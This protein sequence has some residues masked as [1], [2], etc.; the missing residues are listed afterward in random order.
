MNVRSDRTS[1][2]TVITVVS[3][4]PRSGTSLLMQMLRAGGMPLLTDDER[5][6]D[7]DNPRGYFEFDPVK[8]VR[9]DRTWLNQA[10]G[11]A[12]KI[13]HFLL[14]ELPVDPPFA[15][16]VLFMRRP[17]EEVLA[18]QQ[19]MLSRQGKPSANEDVLK[20][21]YQSQVRSAETWMADHACVRSLNVDYHEAL[22]HP[23][24]IAKDICA[25]LEADLDAAAM[26]AAVDPSLYRQRNA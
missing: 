22:T 15:Y 25:F 24:K 18:S 19:A 17:I 7:H 9:A 6:P 21:A 4:I 10:A 23:L 20:N 14:P 16:R 2:P 1:Q 12:V 13:I 11:R 5:A 8:R 26:A 3:G